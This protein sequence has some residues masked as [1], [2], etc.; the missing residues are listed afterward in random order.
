[1][2]VREDGMNFTCDFPGRNIDGVFD[3]ATAGLPVHGALLQL[4]PAAW[5]ASQSQVLGFNMARPEWVPVAV[6][7][8][9][10]WQTARSLGDW[11]L[12]SCCVGPGFDFADFELEADQVS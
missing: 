6:V 3:A 8:A 10:W 1:M 2:L 7:P 5:G 4:G 11:S 9:G 12:V